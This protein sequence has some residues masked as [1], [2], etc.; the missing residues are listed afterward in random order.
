MTCSGRCRTSLGFV[1]LQRFRHFAMSLDF[2]S[3]DARVEDGLRGTVR[4]D[5]VHR[6]CGIAQQCYAAKG[7][8]L[9]WV[10]VHHW[11][12]EALRCACDD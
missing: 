4:S 12:F 11:V 5:R 6:V 10:T 7:P 2:A 1:S 9:D 8:A 3:Q